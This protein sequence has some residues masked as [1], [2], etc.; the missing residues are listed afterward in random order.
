MLTI[1]DDTG[2]ARVFLCQCDGAVNNLL[3]FVHGQPGET[4]FLKQTS[5]ALRKAAMMVNALLRCAIRTNV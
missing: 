4:F 2:T 1:G 5:T 3:Y